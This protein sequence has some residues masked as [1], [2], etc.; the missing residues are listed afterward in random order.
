MPAGLADGWSAR[1]AVT[2]KANQHNDQD[3]PRMSARPEGLHH[4]T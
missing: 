4:P 1:P 2:L 3:I